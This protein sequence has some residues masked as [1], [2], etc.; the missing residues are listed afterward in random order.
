MLAL[1]R[2]FIFTSMIMAAICVFL[3]ERQFRR[4]SMWSLVAAVMAFFGVIHTYQFSGNETV[5]VL[6]WNAGGSW[7]FG[8]LCFAIIFM[9]LHAWDRIVRSRT[10]Q[11]IEIQDE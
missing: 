8:Y 1:E 3:I 6:G 7:A 9:A 5:S 4:A 10:G 2:G 11:G